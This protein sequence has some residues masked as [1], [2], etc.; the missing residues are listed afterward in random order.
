M[1]ATKLVFDPVSQNSVVDR[2][3]TQ[4][5]QDKMPQSV[6]YDDSPFASFCSA[7]VVR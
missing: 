2:F 7:M 3:T 5:E 6:L 1:T 4:A